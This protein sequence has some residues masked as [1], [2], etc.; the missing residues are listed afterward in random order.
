MID[1]S[2]PAVDTGRHQGAVNAIFYTFTTPKS[3]RN[4]GSLF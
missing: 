1:A 4:N 2:L 3:F